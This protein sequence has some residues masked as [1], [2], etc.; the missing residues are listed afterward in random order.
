MGFTKQSASGCLIH[1]ATLDSDEAVLDNINPSNSVPSSNL[2]TVQEE[3]E[4][5][6]LDSF[7]VQVGDLGGDPVLELDADRLALVGSILGTDCH[8]EHGFFGRT[9]GIL[10]HTA[11]VGSVVEILVDGVVGLGLDIDGDVALLTEG[12]KVLAALEALDELGIAPRGDG[13]DHGREGLCAHLE[14]HLVISLARGS[15]RHERCALLGGDADHLLGDA[16][17]RDRGS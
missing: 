1:T 16:G 4:R 2:V 14:A 5:I 8:L 12:Q 10:E 17:T 11:F 7:V 6:S 3:V 15:V 9:H 13:L